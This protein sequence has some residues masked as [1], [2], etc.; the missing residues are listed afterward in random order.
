MVRRNFALGHALLA[1]STFVLS[2]YCLNLVAQDVT[3]CKGP[4]ELEKAIKAH[5]SAGAY[6]ALGAY[7][8]QRQKISCAISAFES[9]VHL[10]PN[11][12]EA[13]FNLALA[14]LQ[15]NQPTRAARELRLAIHSQPENP[16]GHI[17]LGVALSQ[18]NHDDAA[19]DEFKIALSKDSKSV[20]ALDGL[21]K[22]FIAQ[23]RY[24][25]AI[26]YLKEAPRVAM[27]QNDLAI[28]YS[29]NGNVGEALQVLTNIVKQ[30]PSSAEA[31]SNLAIAYTQQ[32]Q[33]RQAVEEFKEAHRLAPND[34]TIRL[35]YVKALVVL[36]E[37]NIALPLITDYYKRKPH[38]FEALYL[39][40][41]VDRGL[42]NYAEAETMLRQAVALNGNSYEVRYN[43]G[44]A[45]AKLGKKQE[46][47]Q[48]LEK[49]VQLKPS[50]S[51]ASFQLAAV[52]RSLGQEDQ[53]RQEL[54]AF[55]EKKQATVKEDIAGT[56]V[57]QANE[58]LQSG[59]A[60]HAVDIYR[61]AIIEDPKNARTRYNLA[62]ALD[63]LGAMAEER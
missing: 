19:I 45:L 4:A 16:L 2:G 62:L 39:M 33:F 31:H 17:A 29:K 55:D 37:F 1:L 27:L 46:A 9:A 7:F 59:D 47:R 54:K 43:L 60:Q 56:K 32:N 20:P 13:R 36:A 51:E 28:A 10:D 3:T 48:Q 41:I 6:D 50:S 21:A 53:A 23:K 24:S 58:Y 5:P 14:L 35:S 49:A 12:W 30:D 25:A 44:F 34:D 52:L 11:S 18:L 63:R 15:S 57:N 42:G 38:D 61:Q 8:G 26:A 40:G 22:S